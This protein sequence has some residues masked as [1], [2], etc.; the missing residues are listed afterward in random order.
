MTRITSVNKDNHDI[1]NNKDNQPIKTMQHESRCM[2]PARAH[3]QVCAAKANQ[4]TR[5][6]V[7]GKPIC[8]DVEGSRASKKAV[9]AAA[10]AESRRRRALSNE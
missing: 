7:L 3:T 5:C 2:C 1:P 4:R 10:A 6:M 9:A 8:A